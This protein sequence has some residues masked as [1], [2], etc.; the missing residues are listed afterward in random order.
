[1]FIYTGSREALSFSGSLP[2]ALHCIVLHCIL[3][4]SVNKYTAAAAA[5]GGGGDDDDDD[6]DVRPSQFTCIFIT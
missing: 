3:L 1:L 6:D 5:A 2:I 4:I